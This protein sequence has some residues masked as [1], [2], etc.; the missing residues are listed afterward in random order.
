MDNEVK[1]NEMKKF[2]WEME[3]PEIILLNE[4]AKYEIPTNDL[5]LPERLFWEAHVVRQYIYCVLGSDDD[6]G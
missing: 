4:Y 2:I 5:E 3:N 1:G 6:T